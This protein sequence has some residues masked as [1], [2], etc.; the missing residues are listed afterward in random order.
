MISKTKNGF[1]MMKLD[2]HFHSNY[3]PDSITLPETALKIAKKKG[4]TLAITE[5]NITSSWPVFKKLSKEIGVEVIFG[6]EI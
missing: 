6:E 1:F 2:M 3:S 5:H 4:L